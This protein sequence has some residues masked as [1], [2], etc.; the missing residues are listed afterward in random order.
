M[1]DAFAVCSRGYSHIIGDLPCQDRATAWT[2]GVS[3]ICAVA[4]GHGSPIHIRSGIGSALA[5]DIA[6][7]RLRDS[8]GL[9]PR[10]VVRHVPA[11]I[12]HDWRMAC[13]SH[14]RSNPLVPEEREIVAGSGFDIAWYGTTLVCAAMTPA[15]VAIIQIGDGEALAFRHD[16]R[17]VRPIPGDGLLGG[18]TRS[19]CD[20][21]ASQ[22]FRCRFLIW[23]AS[24]EI[25]AIILCTDGVANSYSPESLKAFERAVI[26]ALDSNR[27]EALDQLKEWLPELSRQGSADDMAISGLVVK[28]QF[29]SSYPL[30][31]P[32]IT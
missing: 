13:Y 30:W 20:H 27:K 28:R 18:V 11:K 24:A 16:G 23:P 8:L 10:K 9:D 17:V 32:E 25:R 22:E 4:D 21:G 26:D 3:A 15:W 5:T 6:E 1:I 2:D 31:L 19:L 14:Y 7:K 12:L 29:L